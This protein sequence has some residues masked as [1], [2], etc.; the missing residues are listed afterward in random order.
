MIMRTTF[1]FLITNAIAAARPTLHCDRWLSRRPARAP[2][3][4]L[5]LILQVAIINTPPRSSHPAKSTGNAL[6]NCDSLVVVTVRAAAV[7]YLVARLPK[8]IQSFTHGPVVRDLFA[9]RV[10]AQIAAMRAKTID[11]CAGPYLE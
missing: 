11:A 1:F 8:F 10:V 6:D 5:G 4:V 9:T 7:G 3:R 2:D